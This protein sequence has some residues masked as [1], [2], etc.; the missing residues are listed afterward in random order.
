MASSFLSP[1]ASPKM[2]RLAHII[3]LG[4]LLACGGTAGE[5]IAPVV[6]E[7]SQPDEPQ[8]DARDVLSE[9]QPLRVFTYDGSGELVHPDVVVFSQPWRGKRYWYAA[10]P[11]PLGNAAFENPSGYVGNHR[12]DWHLA[13]GASNPLASPDRDAYLSDPDLVHDPARDELRLYYRQTTRGSDQV[14]LTMSSSGVAWSAPV[15]V[16]Q[17][18]RFNL[19]SPAVVRE[20]DG[21]WRM[22][23]VGARIGACAA[24]AGK[25]ELRERRSVNGSSWSSPTAVSL[26]VPGYVPWHWDI[27]YVSA[28]RQYLALVAAFP[29]GTDCSRTAVF[30]A[31]SDD[32]TTW[33][34]SPTPLLAPGKMDALQDLVYRSTFRYF[35]NGDYV[36]VWFSGARREGF[37]FHYALATARYP[38]DELLRRV[39]PAAAVASSVNAA[40]V[41]R[42]SPADSA[43]RAAFV[44]LFP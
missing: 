14:W 31:R 3:V 44:E 37:E 2:S 33:S 42:P 17:D 6:P 18:A 28:K 40:P 23:T 36:T 38:Y 8:L 11:Y 41:V 9:P 15:L 20:R 24:I 43:A 39:G 26:V 21:S 22:W 25:L 34:A 27:Q 7:I 5:P 16:L 10:T 13:P 4:A 12:D 1:P 19:I 35:E 32:G 29:E 30:F